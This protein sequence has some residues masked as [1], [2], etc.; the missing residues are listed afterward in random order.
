ME[1]I[2]EEH[3]IIAGVSHKTASIEIREKLAFD[4]TTACE[5]VKGFHD[6][7]AV[8]ECVLLST[9]NRTELHAVVSRNTEEASR[10]VTERLR[11]LA[12]DACGVDEA[13]YVHTG[14][15]A[16]EHLFGVAAGLD[17]MILGEPQIFGQVKNAYSI[18]CDAACT[19]PTINRLFH[20]AFRV[21]KRVRHMTAVGEGAVS[22]SFAAVE[23]AR[24]TVGDLTGA[25]VLLVG[26]GKVGELS[27]RHLS[28]AGI[29][30]LVIAN[31]TFERAEELASRLN[32]TAVAF[33]DALSL[34]GTVDIVIVSL[35]ADA[36][37]FS[38]HDIAT[39]VDGRPD[40]SLLLVDLGVPRNIA[41]E[42]GGLPAITLRDIDDLESLTLDNMDHRKGEAD[43]AADII[44]D[45]AEEFL[46][47]LAERE[48]APVIRDLHVKCENIRLEELE[49]IRNRVDEATLETIDLVTRRIVRKIL[50]NPVIA[51]RATGSE[52]QRERLLKTVHELF[53][54]ECD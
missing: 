31:R 40:G 35:S 54:K 50:H 18:A 13:L 22:V 53:I 46:D 49:R 51:M 43:K 41:P 45:E 38:A 37:V 6:L 42:T 20:T 2:K 19:G 15:Q 32:G 11:E 28:D 52:A 39:A 16:V 7:E 47:W 27:A 36:P 25:K 1:H 5:T 48:A 34:F 44:A 17:S 9:C 33:E 12:G 10:L 30:S 8:R 21:G 23:L 14:K 24:K 29:G 4:D 26:A 3:F